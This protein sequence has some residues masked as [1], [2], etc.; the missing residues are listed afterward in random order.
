[1]GRTNLDH[2]IELCQVFLNYTTKYQNMF[3]DKYDFS[4][5]DVRNK[6]YDCE[7]IPTLPQYAETI[8]QLTIIMLTARINVY[9]LYRTYYNQYMAKHKLYNRLYSEGKI[10]LNEFN[11]KLRE[12][13]LFSEYA[14]LIYKN[15]FERIKLI[16]ID[17]EYE[18]LRSNYKTEESF[19]PKIIRTRKLFSL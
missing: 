19:E 7:K 13:E 15:E 12:I 18:R 4:L 8:E 10:S 9:R 17:N 16:D 2:E 11:G 14:T 3:T 6:T 5:D 1:M